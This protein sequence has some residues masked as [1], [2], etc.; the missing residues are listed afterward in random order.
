LENLLFCKNTASIVHIDFGYSFG[1][2]TTALP[3]PELLPFRLTRQFEQVLKPLSSKTLYFQNMARTMASLRAKRETLFNVM[4]VFI[5]EPLLDW[6]A[7]SNKKDE[8]LS[9][10]ETSSYSE[11]SSLSSFKHGKNSSKQESSASGGKDGPLGNLDELDL[12]EVD[13]R[14]ARAMLKLS[15]A[16]PVAVLSNELLSRKGPTNTYIQ[17]LKASLDPSEEEQA[18]QV[19]RRHANLRL[20]L[21][22]VHAKQDWDTQLLLVSDQVHALI[23]LAT[24]PSIQMR[25]WI[26]WMGWI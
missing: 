7:K 4:E 10:L 16:H 26:G 8:A 14:I 2:A 21:V 25:Q 3:V 11:N 9:S 20:D 22:N 23:S 18:D 19:A 13:P 5:N 17:A 15:G 1:I 24:E 12:K 6:A